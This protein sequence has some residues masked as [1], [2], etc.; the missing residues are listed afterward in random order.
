LFIY[1]PNFPDRSQ[2]LSLSL[3]APEKATPIKYS[4]PHDPPVFNFFHVPYKF[5][6]PSMSS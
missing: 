3:A 2:S 6:S 4:A 5:R 1:D